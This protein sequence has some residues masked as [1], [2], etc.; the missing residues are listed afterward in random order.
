[1]HDSFPPDD[2]PLAPAVVARGGETEAHVRAEASPSHVSSVG[3][4]GWFTVSRLLALLLVWVL[5]QYVVPYLLDRY[6]YAAARGRQRA[7]YEIAAEGLQSLP[8]ESLSKACQM[9][10]LH[11]GPSVVHIDVR[12]SAEERWP[13]DIA[14]RFGPPLPDVHGQGSGVIVDA[15]G[16]IVT[17]QHVVHNA[18]AIR[19][20]LR[21]GRIVPARIVGVDKMTDLALLK[22]EADNLI[23][24]EWGDS[25][26]MEVGALV[27]AVGSPFGLQSTTTFGVLSG[28]HRGGMAGV[29]YQ[30]F[31]QTDAAVNPGNSGGPLVDTRGRIVGINTAILGEAY[32]GVGFAI[33]SQVAQFVYQRL[34]TSGHVARGWLGVELSEVTDED[35]VRHDLPDKQGA[36]VVRCHDRDGLPS[37]A[38]LA[39]MQPG[40]VI[41]SWNGRAISRPE[42]LIREVAATDVGGQA[43][44]VVRR[45]GQEIRISVEVAPQP[46][47]FGL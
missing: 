47:D 45:A 22:I 8:L 23:A 24:A 46:A 33:P 20:S 26:E 28:K 39:G 2:P 5:L 41:V 19:V 38:R 37:P 16:Y 43:E 11:V 1:M 7:E 12:N 34:K 35:M 44:V 15:S 10:S 13:R 25:E 32:Q 9:V 3:S 30:D 17:N 21:D 31:L 36:L 4:P 6:H 40:D 27:W 18:R 14:T 29:V 42:E